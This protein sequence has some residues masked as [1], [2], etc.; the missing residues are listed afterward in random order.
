MLPQP[1]SAQSLYI[2]AAGEAFSSFDKTLQ[3][4]FG[5]IPMINLGLGIKSKNDAV[6]I[7]FKF[8]EPLLYDSYNSVTMTE[9]TAIG[10]LDL[11][12][13]RF[14][15]NEDDV[16]PFAG[17]Q[18]S[19]NFRRDSISD[20][21]NG[22]TA[23]VYDSGL[24]MGFG[25]GVFAGIDFPIDKKI[26][27]YGEGGLNFATIPLTSGGNFDAGGLYGKIGIEYIF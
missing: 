19:L 16:R 1:A 24:L 9:T 21:Y 18:G 22:Q 5:T 12:Y 7:N 11:R 10:E 3:D 6:E 14:F 26:A 13:I 23:T 8:G 20:S 4:N 25:G 27:L 15:G 17:L 2:E